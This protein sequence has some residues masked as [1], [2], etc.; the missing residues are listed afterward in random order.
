[1]TMAGASGAEQA[2]LQVL[3]RA[4]E[5]SEQMLHLCLHS[6]VLLVHGV[7]A[8]LDRLVPRDDH[9]LPAEHQQPV[10]PR[11]CMRSRVHIEHAL[12]RGGAVH[13]VCD[14]I[15]VDPDDCLVG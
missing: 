11:Q 15:G 2:R 14:R 1:M 10:L 12:E 6:A 7:L 3:Q 8:I 4:A 9:G 5:P 13:G